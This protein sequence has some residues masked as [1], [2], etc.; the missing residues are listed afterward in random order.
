[1]DLSEFVDIIGYEGIYKINK[2]GNIWSCY[3]NKIRKNVLH[4]TG[5]YTIILGPKNNRKTYTIHRLVAIHFIPND[6]KNKNY[7][8][9]ID[10]VR[11]NNDIMNLKWVTKIDNDRNQIS[12]SNYIYEIIRKES[13]TLTYLAQYPVYINGK[14]TRKRKQSTYRH[15]VEEWI[16]QMKKEYPNEYTSGRNNLI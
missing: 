1:M 3:N 8:D 14:Y 10:G 2:N 7:I 11:T 13:G 6:D 4:N 15:I 5:Y 16:E 9:H 12:D